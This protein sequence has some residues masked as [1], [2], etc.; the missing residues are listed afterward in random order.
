MRDINR[1]LL[2]S[3]YPRLGASS[4]LRSL[5]YLPLLEEEGF[6]FTVESLFDEKYLKNIYVNGMRSK[7]AVSQYYIKRL[8]VLLSVRKY[9][10]V[11]VEKE[12]F[13]YLPA[14]FEKILDLYGVRY[15]VDYDDAIFHNYDVSKNKL[16]RFFVGNKINKVMRYS[17]HVVVGNDYL[18][19]YAKLAGVKRLEIIPTVVDHL[20][21]K[22]RE[23]L[24]K[25]KLTVG[26]IGT[27]AT[28][29][30]IVEILPALLA[31]NQQHPFRLLLIGASSNIV[32]YLSGLDVV[33]R[34]WSEATEADMISDMDIGIMP[35]HDGPWERGKCGYKII[36]YMACGVTVIASP[37]GVNESIIEKYKVGFLAKTNQEWTAALLKLLESSCLRSRN[38]TAG[39]KAVEE[40][41]SLESQVLNMRNVLNSSLEL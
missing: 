5:Q 39:R 15:I 20:R 35:L 21:Y 2:L 10:L 4:R 8:F 28:Q 24:T 34:P 38:G 37:V 14:I 41:Y 30:Y 27:P 32:K 40:N 11:W 33:V 12:L 17:Q 1:V 7:L 13:P 22:K 36:Q 9:D 16:V 19:E 23:K 6:E 26:W 29:K 18:A 3:K 31:A 25:G